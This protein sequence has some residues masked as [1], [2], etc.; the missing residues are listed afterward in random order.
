ML[1]TTRIRLNFLLEQHC[2]VT[3]GS[4][5]TGLALA[6]LLVK[7]GAHVSIVARNEEKLQKALAELEACVSLLHIPIFSIDASR[8]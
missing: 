3:G 5:G 6:L 8:L 2:F 4:S 7:R 1:C